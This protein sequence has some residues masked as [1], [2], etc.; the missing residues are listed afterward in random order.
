MR[1]YLVVSTI[2]IAE[3]GAEVESQGG[4]RVLTEQGKPVNEHE[5]EIPAASG[6]AMYESLQHENLSSR[7]GGTHDYLSIREWKS[8]THQ[9]MDP[10]FK[11]TRLS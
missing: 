7:A 8:D 9:I 5:Y 6:A 3:P 11:S 2:L 10:F 1:L 4:R